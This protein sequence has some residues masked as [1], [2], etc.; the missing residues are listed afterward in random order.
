MRLKAL[1]VLRDQPVMPAP[2]QTGMDDFELRR[3]DPQG[4]AASQQP[5]ARNAER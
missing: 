4:H 3:G 5:D 2:R 1:T